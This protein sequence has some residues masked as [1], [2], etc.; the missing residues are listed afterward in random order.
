MIAD[1]YPKLQDRTATFRYGVN[2]RAIAALVAGI[3]PCVPGFI[4]TLKP[5]ESLP[6][7]LKYLYGG[8][9]FFAFGVSG[10]VFWLLTLAL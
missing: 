8:S 1:L 7:A 6:S 2:W 10:T 9:F 4:A 5:N 3:A